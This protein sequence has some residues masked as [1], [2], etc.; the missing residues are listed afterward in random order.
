[1]HGGIRTI[2]LYWLA[3]AVAVSVFF[4][5]ALCAQSNREK[6]EC[7]RLLSA[8]IAAEQQNDAIGAEFHYEECREL[9]QKHNLPQMEAAALH[10]L[11]VIK[12]RNKKFTDSANLFR[13]AIDLDPKNAPILCDFAQLH[14]DRRYYRE[15]ETILKNALLIEPNNQKV[16]FKLGEIIASSSQQDERQVEGLRYLKLAVGEASAYRELARIYRSK[17]DV[18]RAEFAEQQAK[19]AE[20]NS[21]QT[22]P[23][24]RIPQTPP[25]VVNRVER[26]LIELEVRETAEARQRQTAAPPMIQPP[27]MQPF[28]PATVGATPAAAAVPQPQTSSSVSGDPFA[29]IYRPEPAQTVLPATVP[30]ATAPPAVRPLSNQPATQLTIQPT[31]NSSEPQ[32][33]KIISSP[34]PDANVPQRVLTPEQLNQQLNTPPIRVLPNGEKKLGQTDTVNPLRPLPAGESDLVDPNANVSLLATLPSYA[35]VEEKRMLDTAPQNLHSQNQYRE[36]PENVLR[37]AQSIQIMPKAS[38]A[39]SEQPS[40]VLEQPKGMRAFEPLATASRPAPSTPNVAR[41]ANPMSARDASMRDTNVLQSPTTVIARRDT[42]SQFNTTEEN[43]YFAANLRSEQP[44]NATPN[45][46]SGNPAPNNSDQ[47]SLPRIDQKQEDTNVAKNVRRFTTESSPNVVMFGPI[48]NE[49][50]AEIAAKTRSLQPFE[51]NASSPIVRLPQRVIEEDTEHPTLA[52]ISPVPVV[53][54]AVD[55]GDPFPMA[56]AS[57]ADPFPDWAFPV[58]DTP[59]S[60]VEFSEIKTIEPLIPVVSPL[61]P[62]AIASADPLP[63]KPLFSEVQTIVP[64]TPTPVVPVP[65]PT[66]ASADS[67][68][69]ADNPPL[70][71]EVKTIEPLTPTLIAQAET[72]PPSPFRSAGEVSM[73]PTFAEVK[74][75]EPLTPALTA[76]AVPVPLSPFRPAGEMSM[77]PKFAEV[78]MPELKA[79]EPLPRIADVPIETPKDVIA[80]MP[81]RQIEPLPIQ[82]IAPVPVEVPKDVIASVPP[83]QVEP[84]PQPLQRIAPIPAEAPKVAAVLKDPIANALP[85]SD[86]LPSVDIPRL[87]PVKDEPV[88]FAASRKPAANMPAQR[89]A[90]SADQS[91]GFARSKK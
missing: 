53:A 17:G 27:V 51:Q 1:M 54:P 87:P 15:A 47:K 12:A 78:K 7:E 91:M 83:R 30:P 88:G 69:M 67:Y 19:L 21:V 14:V 2:H 62:T 82:R 76:Q 39:R 56:N 74:T 63:A 84:Q 35:P 9:A 43:V 5:P 60:R 20:A 65:L 68:P 38:E 46:A 33:I 48:R 66:V 44:K 64:L 55:S 73:E 36:N 29:M 80:S 32:L 10:R 86:T 50:S 52:I 81:S 4:A 75:I 71:T 58:A 3:I 70:F 31:N 6:Q 23:G 89:V 40:V 45:P 57:V 28:I 85:H 13:R 16:L 59:P 77:E 8:A 34:Q 49:S 61:P 42:P 41:S 72:V 18:H 26:E 37:S 11:A 79:S 90:T 25:A 24:Q 22:H